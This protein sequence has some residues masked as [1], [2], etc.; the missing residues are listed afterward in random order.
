MSNDTTT[1][2]SEVKETPE[3]TVN[4]EQVTEETIGDTLEGTQVEEK[5][6][7]IPTEVPKA[8][9]DKEINRRKEA[10]AELEK[11]KAAPEE[12]Q[13]EVK[14]LA[15]KISKIE[16]KENIARRD[17]VI[18]SGLTKAL[19]E[20]PE[21]KKVA[22]MDVIKEMALNPANKDMTFPQLLDKAYGNALSGK[23]TVETTTPRGGAT[24]QKVDMERT[25]RDPAYRKEVLSDPVS[26]KQ[27]NE[28]EGGIETRIN[29]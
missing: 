1:H 29:L 26:R 13:S 4:D 10:E 11:L 15:D 8:R 12:N 27:Y 17:A 14:V 20:A 28:A 3:E 6:K 24:D 18:E 19:D 2:E 5:A 22:N 9:L 25:R 7:D 23:R 21:Y 16:E